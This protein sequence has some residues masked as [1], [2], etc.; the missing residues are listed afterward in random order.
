MFEY[1]CISRA[2]N[3]TKTGSPFCNLKLANNEEVIN[4]AVWDVAPNVG[5]VPGD[6]V[7]FH[8]IQDRDGKKSASARDMVTG[9]KAVEGHPFY[10]LMPHPIKKEDWDASINKLISFCQ[11]PKLTQVIM[12]FAQKLYEPYS[13][14]PAAT[15][16]H[17]AFQGGLLNH[18]YQMLHMLEGLYPCLPY[19]I[20][21]ERCILAILFHDYGKLMEYNH[22]GE[23]QEDMFLLGHIYISAHT[24]QNTLESYLCEVPGDPKSV[25][26]ESREEIKRIIHCVLAHHGELEYGSPVLPCM[27]EAV[28]VNYLDNLSAKAENI[29]DSG[30]MEKS[31][32]LGTHVVKD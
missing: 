15:T 17:H 29:K 26:A 31:F 11:N 3:T 27:Q 7:R 19:P 32:C 12:D 21:V 10:H 9:P 16:M 25:S 30:N 22:E 8:T 23:A 1:L 28:I 6:I 20:K 2:N 24:L 4:I 18:T 13:K 5:P 14:Y